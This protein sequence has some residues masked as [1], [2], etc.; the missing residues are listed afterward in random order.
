MFESFDTNRSRYASFGVV[1]SMPGE[2]IDSIWLIIDLNL[3]G[4]IPLTN[5]L[6][7]DIMNNEGKVTLL[8]SQ[9]H[10][11]VEMAVDLA[12]PYSPKYPER[13]FAIDDGTRE[14][15]LLPTEITQH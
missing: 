13:V 4:V 9:E 10:S 3:K 8:F 15:I 14:T 7:F 11:D 6:T 2:L 1:A 5:M 12:Y